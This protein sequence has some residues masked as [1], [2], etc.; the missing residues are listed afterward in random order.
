MSI[1]VEHHCRTV[2]RHRQARLRWFGNV[3]KSDA[4]Y[5]RKKMLKMEPLRERREPKRG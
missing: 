3:Q 2:R 5:V 4:V 1:S